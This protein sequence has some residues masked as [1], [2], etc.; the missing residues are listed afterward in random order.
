MSVN[1]FVAA[2]LSAI[3]LL[4]ASPRAHAHPHAWKDVRST[5]ILA[6]SGQVAAIEQ[7]WLFDELY[8]AS[9]I[10][11]VADLRAK[12][13]VAVEALERLDVGEGWAAQIA[14]A[15]LAQINTQGESK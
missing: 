11:G 8:T 6:D 14:R 7:R 2:G 10:E 3:A 4:A 9:L 12:L 13:V 15:A 1:V 5:V